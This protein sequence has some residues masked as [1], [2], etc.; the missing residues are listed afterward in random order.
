MFSKHF[1]IFACW[2][3]CTCHFKQKVE[4]LQTSKKNISFITYNKCQINFIPDRFLHVITRKQVVQFLSMLQEFL[5]I[6][7]NQLYQVNK[8]KKISDFYFRLFLLVKCHF[9]MFFCKPCIAFVHSCF[10][11]IVCR[12]VFASFKFKYS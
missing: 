11:L 8:T 7:T 9:Q 3:M 2:S 4:F 6:F 5:Y 12:I 1:D 10:R